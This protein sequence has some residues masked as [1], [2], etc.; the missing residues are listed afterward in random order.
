M[1]WKDARLSSQTALCLFLLAI[2][3]AELRSWM[4]EVMM[5]RTARLRLEI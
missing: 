3:A 5:R 1:T 4:Y 2:I